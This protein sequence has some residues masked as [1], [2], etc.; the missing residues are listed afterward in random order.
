MWS[1]VFVLFIGA[2]CEYDTAPVE[3]VVLHVMKMTA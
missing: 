1:L 2:A 3:E